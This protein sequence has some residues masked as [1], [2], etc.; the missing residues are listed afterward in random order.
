MVTEHTSKLIEHFNAFMCLYG[1][2][3]SAKE[4][5]AIR[6]ACQNHDLGKQNELFQRKLQTGVHM[7]PGE[8][9]HGVLSCAFLK[10]RQMKEMFGAEYYKIIYQAIYNHHSRDMGFDDAEVSNYIENKLIPYLKV[11]FPDLQLE[12]KGHSIGRLG[13]SLDEDETALCRYFRVKG[14]LNKFDYAASAREEDVYPM[15]TEFAPVDPSASI[16]RYFQKEY[17]GGLNAVQEYM[18]AN[19]DKN[20]VVVASTGSGK[21]EGALLW[22]GS[23]KT[24]YT[25]PLKVSINAI[26]D[27]LTKENGYYPPIGENGDY[28]LGHLHSETMGFFLGNG[29]DSPK[30]NKAFSH[31]ELLR[32][33]AKAFVYP[34]TVC[35][36]DQ[37][38]LFVFKAPGLEIL[39]ATL[40]YSKLIIDEIQAYS[41]SILA[42]LVYGLR[43]ITA[44]GGK[45]C[46]MTATLPPFLLDELKTE[47]QE[48]GVTFELP[49]K[50]FLMQKQRHKIAFNAEHKADFDYNRIIASAKNKKVL[51][52]CNTVKRAQ[53][54]YDRLSDDVNCTLLHSRFIEADRTAKEDRIKRVGK[55]GNTETGIFIST[56]IVEASLDIDF[57]ELHTD[58][59]TADSLL[60]RLG[61]CYRARE[62]GGEEPNVFIVN[63][64]YGVGT[65]Y[66]KD[67]YRFSV[68]AL[69]VYNGRIFTEEDKLA[70]IE[71]VY[72]LQ[73]V[74]NTEYYNNFKKRLGYMKQMPIGAYS[75]GD[76]AD[77]FR[78]IHNISVVPY[79]FGNKETSEVC[80]GTKQAEIR[81]LLQSKDGAQKFEGDKWLKEHSVSLPLANKFY[82]ENQ[83]SATFI[84]V[85]D[86]TDYWFSNLKYNEERGLLTEIDDEA[87]CN[88]L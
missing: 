81:K 46:I 35:T 67:I 37:L 8:F 56:Q 49:E 80:D 59:C 85:L 6:F 77:K 84:R 55:R 50:A 48:V 4:Q 65:V 3:F 82:L 13:E 17:G 28:L 52:I 76:A 26:F 53:Q 23:T 88:I 10:R 16:K 25:L 68:D 30:G 66:D 21:T 69:A 12:I 9:P 57:D 47:L 5:Q 62:Y 20:I 36:V 78:E 32:K 31:A 24:F 71:A 74:K 40:S 29:T 39:P 2:F 86:D 61:R 38:F 87:N 58:M 33:R 44:M 73:K 11:D 70:Y 18:A 42:Y 34:A 63:S 83:K 43:L 45:F 72:S 64:E 19:A 51:I 27:R 41:P 7:L 79:R 14:M 22:A 15:G 1:N 54:V 75:K 60:Q